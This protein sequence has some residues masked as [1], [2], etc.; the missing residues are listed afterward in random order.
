MPPHQ[1]P[2]GQAPLKDCRL[3]TARAGATG[4]KVARGAV[5]DGLLGGVA[6][7]VVAKAHVHRRGFGVAL[8]LAT[9]EELFER[10]AE[11]LVRRHVLAAADQAPAATLSRTAVISWVPATCS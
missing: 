8:A 2:S 4:R 9:R 10:V 11:E 3:Y 1:A 6:I 7:T 5:E